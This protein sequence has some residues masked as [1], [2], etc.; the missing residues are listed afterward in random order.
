MNSKLKFLSLCALAL[1]A[2]C[3]RAT[4][5]ETS[6]LAPELETRP[7]VN[8]DLATIP[9]L[10][11]LPGRAEPA[12]DPGKPELVHFVTDA[13]DFIVAVYPQAAP[14][15]AERFL[16][17]VDIGY[18]NN[19]PIS[20]VVPGFVA[21]FGINWREDFRHW[22][23]DHFDDD[24]TLFAFEPG[25]MAFAKAGANIN[26]TQVFIN[27]A[28][29]NRLADPQYNFAVFAQV[30]EGMEVVESFRSVG[31]AGGGLDQTRLWNNGAAYLAS[32]SEKP[33]TI[34]TAR[35]IP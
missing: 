33:H 32:L 22:R 27:Y 7:A 2:G 34:L 20:R 1:L 16:H 12:P 10:T 8:I 30:V 26:S 14:N 25:T 11:P 24:P 23:D 6:A 15:A 35:R 18:Y 9:P 17:L 3:E 4:E 21:Q 5:P 19:I 31:D 29:N 28:N 13:G